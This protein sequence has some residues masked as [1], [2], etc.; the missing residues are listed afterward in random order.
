MFRKIAFATAL[1]LA[2]ALSTAASAK[3][4]IYCSEASPSGFDP[5]LATSATT[6]DAVGHTVY[7]RL[8]GF[9]KGT[10]EIE[11]ELA[12]SYQVSDDG[13][14]YTFK[15]RPNVKFQTTD[16]FTPT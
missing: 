15:L 7:N 11:P 6:Y 13:L 16:Y 4:F 2:P 5:A 10:T 14:Q 1:L 3:P 12:E 9:K 8:V